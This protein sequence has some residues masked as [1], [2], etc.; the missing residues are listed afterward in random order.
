MSCCK[1]KLIH[2]LNYYMLFCKQKSKKRMYKAHFRGNNMS[3]QKKVSLFLLERILSSA[4]HEISLFLFPPSFC[5]F[6]YQFRESK[7][8]AVFF[9][10]LF[11]RV[12]NFCLFLFSLH[13]HTFF[14]LFACY[15][16]Q[17]IR[18]V[19]NFHFV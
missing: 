19:G 4:Y 7:N 9:S 18:S 3:K 14:S 5:S 17:D 1:L 6:M 15:Q 10:L 2:L 12:E 13:F 16:D 11:K 8:D